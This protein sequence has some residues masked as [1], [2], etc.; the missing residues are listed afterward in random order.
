MGC[1]LTGSSIGESNNDSKDHKSSASASHVG[2][3][4]QD[5]GDLYVNDPQDYVHTQEDDKAADQEFS[6]PTLIIRR[7]QR[8]EPI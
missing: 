2:F 8:M 3:N 5:G 6:G 1:D 7:V 4:I